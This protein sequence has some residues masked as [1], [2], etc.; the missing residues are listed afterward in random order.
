[1]GSAGHLRAARVGAAVVALGLAACAAIP[2]RTSLNVPGRG[3]EPTFASTDVHLEDLPNGAVLALALSGGGMRAA[4]FAAAVLFELEDLGV[5]DHVSAISSV[6]GGALAGG[7]YGLFSKDATRWKRERVRDLLARNLEARWLVRWLLPHNRLRYWLT[8]FDRSDLMMDILDDHLFESRRFKDLDPRGPYDPARHRTRLPKI[9]INATRLSD[10]LN[11]VFTDAQ[12]R[13]F[14]SPLGD[15]PLAAAVMASGAM[16]GAFQNVTLTRFS[17]DGAE[18]GRYEHL[19][20]GGVADNLGVRTLLDRFLRPVYAPGVTTAR[21]R[22]CFLIV[23][24][25]HVVQQSQG[26]TERDTR[27]LIDFFLDTNA[28]DAASALLAQRRLDILE[29]LGFE[30]SRIGR[31]A[32]AEGSLGQ[33]LHLASGAD[34]ESGDASS[35]GPAPRCGIWHISFARL[36]SVAFGA[37]PGSVSVWSGAASVH[38]DL[39]RLWDLINRI[40]TRYRLTGL[41]DCDPSELQAALWDAAR[42]L[43]RED[44]GPLGKLCAWLEDNGL[45]SDRCRAAAGAPP[46]LPPAAPLARCRPVSVQPAHD[47]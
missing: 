47:R 32:Y 33:R 19:Y 22:G 35:A 41:D 4:N 28:A 42:V 26:V 23:V 25:A 18:T 44:K 12:F 16:P 36:S 2:H 13:E 37:P 3:V 10:G 38:P 45:A 46:A 17:E 34:E 5:L 39:E 1:M 29:L 14:G 20:D 15:Y 21:P 11:F 31:E 30:R 24:D 6:S 9:F 7:Y 43:V 27:K 40:A 8:D